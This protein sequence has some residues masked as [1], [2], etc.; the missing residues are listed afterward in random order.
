[1]RDGRQRQR[2]DQRRNALRVDDRLHC[3][4]VARREAPALGFLLR[5]V[6]RQP[7]LPLAE[8]R[9]VGG[10]A[11]GRGGGGARDL[12]HGLLGG[13]GELGFEAGVLLDRRAE[14]GLHRVHAVV[15]ETLDGRRVVGRRATAFEL[16]F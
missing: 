1:R 9:R 7:R 11:L 15:D 12:A 3:R 6:L 8:T 16:R 13:G 4:D 10:A 2:T 14:R 5:E